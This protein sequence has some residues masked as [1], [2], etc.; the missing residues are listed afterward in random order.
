MDGP[1]TVSTVTPALDKAH[2]PATT[3][4]ASRQLRGRNLLL[5]V[6]TTLGGS[7]VSVCGRELL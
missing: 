5:P 2:T 6:S 7:V 3:S 4:A 1:G